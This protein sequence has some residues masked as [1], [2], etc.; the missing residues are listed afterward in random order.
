MKS[1]QGFARS[2]GSKGLFPKKCFWQRR[3]RKKIF[4]AVTSESRN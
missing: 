3:R 1:P 4:W 2:K